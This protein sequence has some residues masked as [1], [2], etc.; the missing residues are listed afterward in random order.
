MY[1]I[2]PEVGTY[3]EPKF[4]REK[5]LDKSSK[6][7]HLFCTPPVSPSPN[8]IINQQFWWLRESWILVAEGNETKFFLRNFLLTAAPWFWGRAP[9]IFQLNM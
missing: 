2:L 5:K 1:L 3:S 8:L 6:L 4:Q 9:R 7:S